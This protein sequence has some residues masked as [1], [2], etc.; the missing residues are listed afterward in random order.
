[1]LN[2]KLSRTGLI[3]GKPM[4]ADVDGDGAPD[5]IAKFTVS[6][7]PRLRFGSSVDLTHGQRV[8]VAVSGPSGR[9]LW[10]H[11]IDQQT[12]QMPSWTRDDGIFQVSTPNGSLVAFVDQSRWIGLDVKTGRPN[13]PTLNF[14]FTP[15]SPIEHVD[16]DGDGNA[17]IL[18]L[19]SGKVQPLSDSRIGRVFL[20][21]GQAAVGEEYRVL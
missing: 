10:N 18:A 11:L 14:G 6:E 2:E 20:D 12:P 21:F 17:E 3:I 5:L 4:V 19:E 7:H 16:L 8:V 13:S 1:M 15:I 9:E